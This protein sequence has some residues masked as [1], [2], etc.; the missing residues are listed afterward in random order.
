MIKKD[1]TTTILVDQ[2][3]EQ[4][5]DAVN[6][7]RGWWS[8]EVEGGTEE[9]NDEFNYHYQDIHSCKMKLIELVPNE[10][11]VWLVLENYFKFTSD[12]S[13]W[14]DTRVIFEISKKGDKTQLHF[15]HLGLVPEYECF[16][17]CKN[18]WTDYIQNSLKKPDRI[19]KRQA[20]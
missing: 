5:F 7:V 11:V 12:K 2:S 8:E 18:A 3:P 16:D 17:I 1:F 15:T 6:N 4:V 19:W 10:K 9:L 14:I 13:E 20:Q